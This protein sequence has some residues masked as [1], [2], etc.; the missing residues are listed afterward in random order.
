VAVLDSGTGTVGL[1]AKLTLLVDRNWDQPNGGDATELLDTVKSVVHEEQAI[2]LRVARL[3]AWARSMDLQEVGYSGWTAFVKAFSPWRMSQTRALVRL[4]DSGLEVIED[5]AA[6]NEIELTVATRAPSELGHDASPEAQKKWIFDS[7]RKG[8]SERHRAFM[9]VLTGA[10]MRSVRRARDLGSI[11]IGSDA[12]IS[13]I[14]RTLVEWHD[15]KLTNDD[16]LARARAT[17]PIPDR[18]V[19]RIREWKSEGSTSILGPW[20]PP[21]DLRSCVATLRSTRVVLERRRMLLGLAYVRIRDEALW[22]SVP[23]CESLEDLCRQLGI[24]QRTW[25]RHAREA[26]QFVR[27]P[28]LR[29]EVEEGGLT[30][31]QVM[32]VSEH[33]DDTDESVQWWRDLAHRLG[34][35][36]FLHAQER[37]G[38]FAAQYG[39]ALDMAREVETARSRKTGTDAQSRDPAPEI[40]AVAERIAGHLLAME[41]TGGIGVALRDDKNRRSG[42]RE[43]TSIF[44][45]PELLAAARYVLAVVKLPRAYG[46]RRTVEH[47]LY[48]CQ[49]PRCRRRTL[50]VHPHHLD[51]KQHGGSDEPWNLV[52]LC[53]ACHL[54]GVHSDRMSVVRIE[55]WLIWTWPDHDAV[56]MHSP[57]GD[58]TFDRAA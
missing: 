25:Q 19:G 39:P 4:V 23:G 33:A 56:I 46:I 49:N 12:P 51:E 41:A 16:I 34:G 50:R 26:L 43:P 29:K 58:L 21:T 5:A 15:Q 13:V 57:V 2:K 28:S 52:T 14:D 17:P 7:K 6:K 8:L 11:L 9:E 27:R 37:H 20:V 35:A 53:P 24:G 54:R 36:E 22:K 40:G 18:L 42:G 45:P 55:D 32:F 30:V 38:D 1:I 44:V 47:D 31:D 10:D 3:M 48:T